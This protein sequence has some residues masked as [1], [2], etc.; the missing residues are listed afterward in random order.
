[1]SLTRNDV[2]GIFPP[3]FSPFT[4]DGD[5]DRA[6]FIEDIEY[7]LQHPVTGLVVGGSTGEGH[8]LT[9]EE[10]TELTKIAVEH[11]KGRIPIVTGII[12]TTT[13]DAVARGRAAREVGAAGVMV[14]PPI[15]QSPSFDGMIDFYDR[16]HKDTELPV[17][18]YNVLSHAPVTPAITQK[19]AEIGAIIATKESV[20]GSFAT[21]SELLDTV[22]DQISVTWAQDHLLYPGLALGAT[23]SISGTGAMFPGESIAMLEAIKRNDYDEAKRIHFALAPLTRA[24]M[25][26]KNWPAW[27]KAVATEQGRQVGPARLPFVPLNDEEL[28][29]VKSGLEIVKTALAPATV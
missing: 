2:V 18:I 1:M 13:R 17:I 22:A 27:I 19:L 12:T 24:V 9:G 21:L 23:G 5:L 10:L 7:Q 20:G 26:G 4:A 16:I 25:N 8:A 11:V 14:T 6:A 28:Q 15:Y 3:L 29:A